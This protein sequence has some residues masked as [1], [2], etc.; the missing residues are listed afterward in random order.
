M[1]YFDAINWD[2]LKADI[3]KAMRQGMLVVKKG[4][5]VAKKKADELTEEGERQ[6]HILS[7]KVKMHKGMSDLGARVYS[8]LGSKDKNLALD[9]KVKAL[10][11]QIKKY[12]QEIAVIE[13]TPKAAVKKK[14]KK[15]ARKK[16]AKKM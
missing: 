9:P 4:A 1:S 2:K 16:T 5:M 11:T 13:K 10:A 3:E 8:L 6:Y 7:L 15:K 12:K 14:A